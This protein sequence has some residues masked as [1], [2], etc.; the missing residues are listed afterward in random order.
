MN[1]PPLKKAPGAGELTGRKLIPAPRAYHARG[2][3]QS[4]IIWKRWEREARRLF[5][6]FWRTAD[7]RRLRAFTTHI[8][9]MRM[10][11]ARGN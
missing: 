6:E 3:V 7:D 4:G 8:R 9:A 11:A 5:I 2:L 10:R 1:S